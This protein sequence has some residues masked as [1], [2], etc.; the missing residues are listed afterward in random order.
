[1]IRVACCWELGAGAGHVHHLAVMAE[2]LKPAGHEIV[3]IARDLATVAKFPNLADFAAFQAPVYLRPRRGPPAANFAEVLLGVGFAE[4]A[5][6][7]RMV[8]AWCRLFQL[9]HTELVVSQHSPSA[10]LAA[11]I[12]G[13]PRVTVGTGFDQPPR[14]APM[15]PLQPWLPSDPARLEASERHVLNQMNAVL[16]ARGRPAFSAL[17]EL[18][19]D[20]E[21]LLLT[22]PEFDHYGPRAEA[23]YLG[24]H[25]PAG[26][27]AI[28]AWPEGP[29]AKL[30][31]Y[32]RTGY[33]DFS[34]LMR[35]LAQL[36]LP[37]LAVV[38]DATPDQVKEFSTPLLRIST[39]PVDLAVV[40]KQAALAIGHGGAGSSMQLILGGCPMLLL[41]VVVEQGQA[42][43][44][45]VRAGVA[46]GMPPGQRRHD[47][48]NAIRRGLGESSFRE[49]AQAL[50]QKYADLPAIGQPRHLLEACERAVISAIV[51][52][53][54][55]TR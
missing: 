24:P 38:D 21:P 34:E 12:L 20:A 55:L 29:G 32:Y 33:P 44:R 25:L 18:F 52:E 16:S 19:G 15:P 13:L 35:H 46:M 4:A 49:R 50:A 36:K 28:P 22:L 5:V 41:P 7:G 17:H 31:V 6:L 42:G 23:H 9:L 40:A 30:F 43:Y 39:S 47:F 54:L 37:T 14:V 27:K 53:P 2:A 48:A 3:L 26:S 11:Y 45:L 1:M 51:H 10:L 8:D